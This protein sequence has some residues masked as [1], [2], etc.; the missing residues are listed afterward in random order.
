MKK[1]QKAANITEIIFQKEMKQGAVT[2]L[3]VKGYLGDPSWKL[4]PETMTL[5]EDRRIVT[6]RMIAEKDPKAIAIQVIKDFERE[7]SLTFPLS[8]KWTVRCNTKSIEI[9]VKD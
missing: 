6:I 7:I 8:G 5:D 1:F 9:E 3:N 2:T 4:L